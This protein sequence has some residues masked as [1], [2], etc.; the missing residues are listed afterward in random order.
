VLL[1]THKVDR[2]GYIAK[3]SDFGLSR[4]LDYEDSQAG[5]VASAS[6]AGRSCL[7]LEAAALQH[8]FVEATAAAVVASRT[9][10]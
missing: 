7:E 1:K 10:G 8:S 9:V 6:L 2:R 5:W 4:A 3:V